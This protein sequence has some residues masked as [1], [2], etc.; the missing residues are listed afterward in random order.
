MSKVEFSKVYIAPIGLSKSFR[1]GP[2]LRQVLVVLF[3]KKYIVGGRFR[4]ERADWLQINQ[5]INGVLHI[6]SLLFLA[7]LFFRPNH[8]CHV[9]HVPQHV[10]HAHR[11][12]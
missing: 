12:V 9:A 6:P 4:M 10:Y 8:Q 7:L 2:S 3:G 5:G 1:S 11:M